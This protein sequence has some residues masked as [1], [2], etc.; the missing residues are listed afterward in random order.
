MSD[1]ETVLSS[2]AAM[3]LLGLGTWQLRGSAARQA[4]LWAL[5]AGYRHADTATMYGN[6][7]EIGAALRE[8][9]LPREEV[10]LTTKLPPGQAGNEAA[11]LRASLDALGVD[12]V[13]LWL[14][15]WPPGG[16]GVPVWEAFL[17]LQAQGLARSI[18]VSNYSPAQVDELVQ[19]TGSAP[20]V[21]Q[22]EWSPFLHDPARL[23]H[24]RAR[25]VVL[26]GY[27]PFKSARLDDPVLADLA[28]RH[29][30]TPAQVIVR[31]HVQ[32]G[33]VVIPKSSRRERIETNADVWDFELPA[34]DMDR[35]DRLGSRRR[36]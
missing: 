24:S 1:R 12:S 15:H 18:G 9:G 30:K 33:I 11:T 35:I 16:A 13:D 23:D 4:V 34:E 7:R 26:E 29:A 10:F 17:E 6:E 19:A 36:T 20:A 2:G 31:W 22:V 14:I 25:G 32:H 27:S 8:S 21:N 28:T 3:P 5:E